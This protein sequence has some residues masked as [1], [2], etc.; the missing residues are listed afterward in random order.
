M[1]SLIVLA[2]TCA[3]R[4]A[5]RIDRQRCETLTTAHCNLWSRVACRGGGAAARETLTSVTM[6]F[7]SSVSS[8]VAASENYCS[9]SPAHIHIHHIY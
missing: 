8:G 9:L 1:H 2:G 4:A 6:L 5:L 7:K 3:S